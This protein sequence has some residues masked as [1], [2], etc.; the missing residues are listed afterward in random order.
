M[1]EC[2]MAECS[3]GNVISNESGSVN[4]DES[5]YMFKEVK[6]SLCV[7]DLV[8]VT[9]SVQKK[10]YSACYSWWGSYFLYVLHVTH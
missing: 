2:L 4:R 3:G 1:A 6:F 8:V 9:W 10:S 5:N 7:L